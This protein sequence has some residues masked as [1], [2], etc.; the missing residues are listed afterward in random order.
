MALEELPGLPRALEVGAV[1]GLKELRFR[2]PDAAAHG[3]LKR[4][5][6]AR[7]RGFEGCGLKLAKL[8]PCIR[9]AARLYM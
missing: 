6:G 2:K 5:F 3:I 8:R 7:G 1:P 9:V 4:L